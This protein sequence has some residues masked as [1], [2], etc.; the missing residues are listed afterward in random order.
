MIVLFFV[1]N[2]LT[3]TILSKI[4]FKFQAQILNP[5]ISELALRFSVASSYWL[6][7]QVLSGRDYLENKHRELKAKMLPEDDVRLITAFIIH[8]ALA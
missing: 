1:R 6:I 5:S 4:C 2:S 3:E 7:Q 8:F